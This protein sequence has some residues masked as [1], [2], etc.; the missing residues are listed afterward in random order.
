VSSSIYSA[1]RSRSITI[2]FS[3]VPT[4]YKDRFLTVIRIKLRRSVVISCLLYLCLI[5]L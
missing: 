3:V 5:L 1:D 2:V 4:V